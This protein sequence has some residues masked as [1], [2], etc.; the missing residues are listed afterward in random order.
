[1]EEVFAQNH[2]V[3]V[4]EE[5]DPAVYFDGEVTKHS[6]NEE[7]ENSNNNTNVNA[8][9]GGEIID[10]SIFHPTGSQAKDIDLV[11]NQGFEVDDDNEPTPKI[12]PANSTLEKSSSTTINPGQIWGWDVI[13]Q[14]EILVSTIKMQPFKMIGRHLER[15][16][17]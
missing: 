13:N 2:Y 6:G 9:A 3:V 10:E 11:R 8:E 17:W 7:F 12:I 14:H 15:H 1:M 4:L 5:G 16:T